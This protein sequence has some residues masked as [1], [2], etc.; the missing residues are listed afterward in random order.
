MS[1]YIGQQPFTEAE[2]SLTDHT[3]ENGKTVY[4]VAYTPNYL[5]VYLNG[6]MLDS[7]AYTALD[8][9]SIVLNVA[10]LATDTLT[11]IAW[12]TFQIGDSLTRNT[13][14]HNSTEGQT[15]YNVTYTV[16]FID[17]YLNGARLIDSDY[18]ATNGST[19]VLTVPTA[20][21][22]QLTTV[23]FSVFKLHNDV[24][25]TTIDHIVV[26]SQ[27]LYS[28][29]YTPNFIDVYLNGVRLDKTEFVA[30]N[31]WE[32]VLNV[33]TTATDTLTTIAWST[34]ES[35]NVA[36]QQL[37]NVVVPTADPLILG[38]VWE[39]DGVLTVSTGVTHVDTLA[40]VQLSNLSIPTS[41]PL[42]LGQVWENDG[43]L[44]VST[45]STL[46]A[47]NVTSDIAEIVGADY[48]TN[49]IKISQADYDAIVTKDAATLY[50]IV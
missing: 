47:N 41:D 26:D 50:T 48:I 38:Q 24:M 42:I 1:G 13:I 23:T 27:S 21:T 10:T 43:V 36:N 35:A 28:V 9:S 29:N 37:T 46:T 18:T 33:A 30:S 40:N 7:S 3:V 8:S 25:R 4:N 32:I 15:V 17:V 6:V 16:G 45:G 5:D 14:T 31:G 49:I 19:V 44:T 34:F 2:R 22:D 12:S 11:T 20:V 39:N